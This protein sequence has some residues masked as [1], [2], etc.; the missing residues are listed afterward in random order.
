M[1]NSGALLFF[2]NAD[3]FTLE[4]ISKK[5][6]KLMLQVRRPTGATAQA[7][8]T[9]AREFRED[10]R[11]VAL[12]ELHEVQSRLARK[13]RRLLVLSADEGA[14]MVERVIYHAAVL[15]K[16]FAGRFAP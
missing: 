13:H 10:V 4:Y 15:G 14:L 12:L 3:A 8:L 11:P 1:G 7:L 5:L 6:G 16:A 2:G 9:G